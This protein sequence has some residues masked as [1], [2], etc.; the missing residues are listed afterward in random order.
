MAGTQWLESIAIRTFRILFYID[1]RKAMRRRALILSTF[2]LIV[3]AGCAT[4]GLG[5][6]APL[7][8]LAD[9]Q[10]SEFRVLGPSL[11]RPLGGAS[12]RLFARVEN[13]NPFG[14]TLTRLMGTLQLEGFDA[15]DADLPLGL[16]LGAHQAGVVPIDIA[17]SFSSLP[18]LADALGRAAN[19]G[20]VDYSLRGTVTV[21]AGS[22]GQ[23]TFG[24][25]TF[26]EGSID[27]LR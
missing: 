6:R 4:F 13:P 9:E 27:V 2:I 7:F 23:P 16:S 20:G 19:Q 1:N 14:I 21:D 15:A 5:I 24:P 12:V 8:E 18:G 10:P 25:M 17:L 22:I 26:L 11:Q 3:F